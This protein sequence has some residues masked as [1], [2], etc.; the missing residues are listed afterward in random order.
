M[1]SDI[2][3]TFPNSNS[4]VCMISDEFGTVGV[5]SHTTGVDFS[6]RKLEEDARKDLAE[7]QLVRANG[8]IVQEFSCVRDVVANVFCYV[9]RFMDS[10]EAE[11]LISVLTR[12]AHSK[13]KE[14]MESEIDFLIDNC[15]ELY[16][17]RYK[18]TLR[19][20]LVFAKEH[21]SELNELM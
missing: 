15:A 19:L 21:L 14:F 3:F 11:D 9:S 4:A 16:E 8:N 12:I 18:S 1:K 20:M 2:C 10:E 13:N 7:K 5:A 17:T 6:Y